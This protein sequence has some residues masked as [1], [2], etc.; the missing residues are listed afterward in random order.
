MITFAITS[1]NRF[2]LLE[3]TLDSFL[4]LNKYPIEKYLLHEDSG[5]LQCLERIFQKY[6]KQF[7]IIYQPKREGLSNA[8][9]NLLSLVRTPYV[10][11]C[12]DDWLFDGNRWFMQQ[13]LEILEKYSYIH[14]VWIRAGN[15]HGHPLGPVTDF[16]NT[17]VR[18]VKQGYKTHWNG[19]SLNPGLRRMSDLKLFFPNGLREYGDEIICAQRTAQFDYRAVSLVNHACKHIG[20]GRHTANFKV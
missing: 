3:Q 5:N 7:T 15:D 4:R 6:G 8:L 18:N 12:E 9:D 20:Y 2:D 14:Q 16:G 13:S 19:F 17:Q 11:T 1:S 10:F